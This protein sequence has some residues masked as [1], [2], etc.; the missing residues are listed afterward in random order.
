MSMT[1]LISLQI[2]SHT[3]QHIPLG[4]HPKHGLDLHSILSL[5]FDFC[6]VVAQW[7]LAAQ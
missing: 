1:L 2:D 3:W 5:L 4:A 7:R 6:H